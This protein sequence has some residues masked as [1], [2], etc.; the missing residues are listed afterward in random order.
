MNYRADRVLELIEQNRKIPIPAVKAKCQLTGKDGNAFA[1][2]GRARLAMKHA[3]YPKELIDQYLEECKRVDYD[4][5][6]V[7]TLQYVED[8]GDA[9]DDLTEDD[10]EYNRLE[11]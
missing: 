9:Y 2:M 1:V 6:L 3:N 8:Y 5:M 4:G 10:F 7:L 11:P